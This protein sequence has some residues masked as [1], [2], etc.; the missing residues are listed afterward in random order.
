MK[1]LLFYATALLS[2][3]TAIGGC[4]AE[5]VIDLLIPDITIKQPGIYPGEGGEYSIAY[6]LDNPRAGVAKSAKSTERWISFLSVDEKKVSF[7]LSVNPDLKKR[8]G[9]IILSY[10]DA[11]DV[12]IEIRQG[13]MCERLDKNGTANCYI[14]DSGEKYQFATVKGNSE[15]SV[16]EVASAEVLW[17]TIGTD[18]APKKGDLI[19][20]L[21]Y[22]DDTISFKTNTF[23]G[24]A[25]IAAKD[26]AGKILWSWHIWIT[27][28]PKDQVYRNNAGTMMDRNLGAL[29]TIKGDAS[30]IGLIYQW[31]RK[32]PFLG[33]SDIN[34]GVPAKS[35]LAVRPDP[36]RK[37][38]TYGTME[39]ATANPTTFIC[40]L[41]ENDDW[42]Y[43][44]GSDLRWGRTKTIYDPCPPGYKI[45]DGGDNGIW[46]K[47]LGSKFVTCEVDI[48][49]E[50]YRGMD[51][52]KSSGSIYYFTSSYNCWYP[53]TFDYSATTGIMNRSSTM[54]S[55]WSHTA[56]D[57]NL[58]INPGEPK[59]IIDCRD[60]QRASGRAVRCQKE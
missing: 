56:K 52:G 3:A 22:E 19:K 51:L 15:E 14:A 4:T 26:K 33:S 35:T 60:R 1:K 44:T 7:Y 28:E 8:E 36:V 17:E 24:N 13:T 53:V 54:G 42:C 27:L 10:G 45:P 30:A 9:T 29:T 55:Y 39:Y 37:N 5:D 41:E 16:G 48:K 11:E 21:V 58:D 49:D 46:A 23:K 6:T 50:E 40:G 32:D 2:L 18:I 20:E 47:V 34:S 38:R 43:N 59:G 57:F 31:G 12:R 25:L